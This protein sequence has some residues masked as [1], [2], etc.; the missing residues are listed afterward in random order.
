MSTS[1]LPTRIDDTAPAVTRQERRVPA[2]PE[3]VLALLTDVAD[4]PRWQTKVT[5]AS[6]ETPVRLGSSFTWRSGV[7]IA[8]TI[9]ALEA[10]R[11]VV[12]TGR[13]IGTRAIHAWTLEE[14]GGGT[15]VRTEESM[16]GWLPRLLRRTVQ[17]TLD[18][19][20][21]ATLD[22]LEAECRR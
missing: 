6:G 12:W 4:W 14:S 7:G 8:S 21:A 19:G 5:A 1:D 18:S 16:D 22:D 11:L 20:V 10:D 15:L 2:S 13:A 3:R 9:T 17:R